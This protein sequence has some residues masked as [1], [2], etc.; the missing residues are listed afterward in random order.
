MNRAILNNSGPVDSV[1]P[2]IYY[3]RLQVTKHGD[4]VLAISK[5]GYLTTGI[6]VGKT[7]DSTSPIPIGKKFTDWEVGGELTDYD[8]AVTIKIENKVKIN[9][10]KKVH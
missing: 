8:G 9:P 6:L 1:I 7:K 2:N 10:K 5:S 4:I 3:P